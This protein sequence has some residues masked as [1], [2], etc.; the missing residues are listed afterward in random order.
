MFLFWGS[1]GDFRIVDQR[2]FAI[3]IKLFFRDSRS[4][5]KMLQATETKTSNRFKVYILT[6]YIFII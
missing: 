1:A 6:I 4:I 2:F 5:Q 3:I